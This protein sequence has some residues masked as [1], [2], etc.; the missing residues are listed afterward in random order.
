MDPLSDVLTLLKVQSVATARLEGAGAWALR[1]PAYEHMKFGMVIAGDRWLWTDRME[2]KI[3]LAPGDFFLLTDGVPYCFASAP[4]APV[5]DSA[6][7][8]PARADEDG[9]MRF[10]EGAPRTVGVGGRFVFDDDASRLLLDSLPPLIHIRSDM[11]GIRALTLAWE[12]IALETER[13][14]PGAAAIASGLANIVLVGMLRAH[15]R[16]GQPPAGWL[17]ALADERI[18]QALRL[19]HAQTGRRWRVDDLAAAV[20][21]SRTSFAER[22]RTRVGMPPLEYLTRWR[23]MLARRAL[24]TDTEPISAIALRIGYESDTAFGLAFRK[25]HGVSPGRYR[26]AMRARHNAAA[27]PGD[28]AH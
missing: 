16:S 26:I 18:G 23:M 3:R 6:A 13:P 24:R 9:V 11:P 14:E 27:A 17:G 22:F 4:D 8:L 25:H 1:F 19:M 28:P 2:S 21:M 5:C 20:A 15:L 10:G 12:L 7:V